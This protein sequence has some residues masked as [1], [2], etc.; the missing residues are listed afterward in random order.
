MFAPDRLRKLEIYSARLTN[1][2][3]LGKRLSQKYRNPTPGRVVDLSLF[4]H[5]ASVS[6]GKEVLLQ[7]LQSC[8][9]IG[10]EPESLWRCGC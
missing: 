2:I 8:T 6:V 10:K 7:M 4:F 3:G 9:K 1:G 5:Q